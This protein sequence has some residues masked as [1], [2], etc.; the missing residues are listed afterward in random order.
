[1]INK[2]KRS[3][4]RFIW[5][6]P[7]AI[8]IITAVP[9]VIGMEFMVNNM[10]EA[11]MVH[12]TFL[13]GIIELVCVIVFLIPKTRN[14]GFLLVVAYSGGIIATEWA[15]HEPIIPGV[16]VQSLLWIGMYFENPGLFKLR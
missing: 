13:V 6:L 7:I 4:L 9:K 12:M 3:K 5:I 8:L 14:I 11:G 2:S 1:M 10:Q 16:L 15:A